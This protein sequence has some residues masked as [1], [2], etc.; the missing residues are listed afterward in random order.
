MVLLLIVAVAVGVAAK[1]VAL[2]RKRAKQA[3]ALEARLWDLLVSESTVAGLPVMPSV[4]LPLW[5]GKPVTVALKGHVPTPH[6]RDTVR[7]LIHLE[8]AAT[9]GEY[10]LDDRLVVVGS[11]VRHAA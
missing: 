11:A 3:L 4:Q 7:E 9:C 6:L 2:R 10:Y 8:M 5:R 1:A